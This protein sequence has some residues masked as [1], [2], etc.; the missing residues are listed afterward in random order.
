[1]DQ[2]EAYYQDVARIAKLQADYNA[3]FPSGMAYAYIAI[4]AIL[5]VV[6][7]R[8]GFVAVV[9]NLVLRFQDRVPSLQHFPIF[10]VFATTLF[11]GMFFNRSKIVKTQLPTDKSMLIFFGIASVGLLLIAP[12]M[13][14]KSTFFLLSGMMFYFFATRLIGTE[15]ELR[16]LTLFVAVCCTILGVEALVAVWDEPEF[17]PFYLGGGRVR[18]LQGIGYYSNANE[19][20]ML[21]IM[22]IPFLLAVVL[23]KSS[24]LAKCTSVA[25]IGVL[26]FA[27]SKTESRTVM[28]CFTLMLGLMFV[29]KSGGQTVKKVFV[30]GVFAVVLVF[31]L[32][33]VPGPI[34]ERLGSIM[35]YENDAS[36]QG[37]VRAWDQGWQM[38][39]WYPLTG[40]GIARWRV[41]HGLAA[42]NSY[43]NVLAE[44]GFIGF[45]FYLR[46]IF[47]AFGMFRGIDSPEVN[48]R[49]KLL[50]LSVLSSFSGY[51]LYIFF[52][53]QSYSSNT[54]L[55]LGLCCAVGT[56]G[57]S[58]K[59]GVEPDDFV[60]R[61]VGKRRK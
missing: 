3:A 7:P 17:T 39:K 12:G 46:I 18:R 58:Q 37:R 45:Y 25:M 33:F 5:N 59:S 51:L 13:F 38:V 48:L 27:M 2:L 60:N 50:A 43:V 35:N 61:R 20:G 32:S 30:G 14:I 23:G 1:M 22:P 28:V 29:L 56:I 21:M 6:N 49:Q 24:F 53:N 26:V 4:T 8:L 16:R 47:Q 41:Y 9:G 36:F 57:L 52:G 15:Q 42:H 54:Y 44:T 55:Y 34:Q 40:V 31:A 10:Q 19:F 11:L